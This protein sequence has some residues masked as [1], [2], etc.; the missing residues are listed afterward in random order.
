LRCCDLQVD[1]WLELYEHHDKYRFVGVLATNPVEDA[2]ERAMLE[3]EVLVVQGGVGEEGGGELDGDTLMDRGSA[4]YREGKV[5][6]AIA[7]WTQALVLFGEGTAVTLKETKAKVTKRA[8]VLLA[9]ASAASK[10]QNLDKSLSHSR[11]AIEALEQALGKKAEVTPMYARALADHGVFQHMSKNHKRALEGLERSVQVYDQAI[12]ASG[13]DRLTPLLL[14]MARTEQF[15]S[16]SSLQCQH[17]SA[18]L[19]FVFAAPPHGLHRAVVQ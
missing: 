11:E 8:N 10:Q 15:N 7:A 18:Y 14:R 13:E 17:S 5:D 4:L 6:A 19:C 16:E 9:L 12:A 3:E 2:V 1:R